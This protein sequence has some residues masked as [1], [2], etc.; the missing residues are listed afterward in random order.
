MKLQVKQNKRGL[1]IN[2]KNRN[3]Y[4]AYPEKIWQS[5]SQKAKNF[6][7]N[8]LAFL[9]TEEI[10]L[11]VRAKKVEYNTKRPFFIKQFKDSVIKE[12][13]SIADDYKLSTKKLLQQFK[14]IKFVFSDD[15]KKPIK[16][17]K[18]KLD[19]E[20]TIIPFSCGK[21]SLLS[22]ALAKELSLKPVLVHIDDTTSPKENKI[23]IAFTK[24]LAKEQKLK[25]Y[26]VKNQIEKLNDFEF[27]NRA[28]TCIG[29]AHMITSF[30]FIS[31]PFSNFFHA[32]YI[33]Q[34][35]EKSL[36]FSYKNNKNYIC[37]PSYD[38]TVRGMEK[39]NK[40][41]SVIGARVI[42][43]LKP[44]KDIT[45][46]RILHKR[47]KNFAKYQISCVGLDA[48]SRKRWCCACSTCADNFILLK[49][50]NINTKKIGMQNMLS[51]KYKRYYVL[52]AGAEGKEIDRYDKGKEARDGQLLAFYLAYKNHA[53]GYLIDLFKK[54]FLKEV[55]TREDKLRKKFFK[56]YHSST[57]E[58]L[59][60]KIRKKLLGIYK[61]EL[62]GLV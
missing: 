30:P 62:K 17:T 21:D 39:Q 28:E 35:N 13:P 54:R 40:T 9:L 7:T 51:K 2:L 3:F 42:S 1:S 44:I 4:L 47:Y 10:P 60:A 31:L 18:L 15:N 34:G 5:Y 48:S 14:N 55:L 26:V 46:T 49:A 38:Q 6:L 57:L 58:N 11:L 20:K 53:R 12:I 22:A 45:I 37:Y 32:K 50:N 36:D 29:F 23:K 24:K 43:F 8:E 25:Y 33:L 27:W 61:E 19:K 59:P 16:L 56:I 52:F 41:L